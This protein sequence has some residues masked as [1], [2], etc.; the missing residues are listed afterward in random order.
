MKPIEFPEQNVIWA[1]NQ[2]EYQPLPAHTDQR[3]T[4]SCWKLEW[5]ERI[6]L[7]FTGKLWLQQMNFG[8][9][10]QPQFMTVDKPFESR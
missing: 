5:R 8:E 10:L 1:K 6:K 4:V 2:K 3:Q 7:F 9:P